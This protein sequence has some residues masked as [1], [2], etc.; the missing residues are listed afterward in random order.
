MEAGG[1]LGGGAVI[2]G[3]KGLG[4]RHHRDGGPV[5]TERQCLLCI[6]NRI[7]GFSGGS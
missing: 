3:M 1:K 7:R 2:G 4:T 5:L 6:L